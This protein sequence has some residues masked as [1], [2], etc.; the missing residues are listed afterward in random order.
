MSSFFGRSVDFFFFFFTLFTLEEVVALLFNCHTLLRKMLLK[1]A[2]TDVNGADK[3]KIER[4]QRK[5]VC[6]NC[7][8]KRHSPEREHKIVPQLI[9]MKNAH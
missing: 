5:Q 8:N 7:R 6:I 3:G 2:F 1:D 9:R 4:K